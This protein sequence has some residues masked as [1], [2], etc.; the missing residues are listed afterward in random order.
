MLLHPKMQLLLHI[1][2]RTN[3]KKFALCFQ[4][5]KFF[6]SLNIEIQNVGTFS[7]FEYRKCKGNSAKSMVT[8]VKGSRVIA[9]HLGLRGGFRNT[10]DSKQNNTNIPS[11]T[12]LPLIIHVSLY[13]YKNKQYDIPLSPFYYSSISTILRSGYACD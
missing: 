12:K 6:N 1:P 13:K 5:P 2:C 3:I 8:N 10:P 4:G 7:L 11:E 9:L